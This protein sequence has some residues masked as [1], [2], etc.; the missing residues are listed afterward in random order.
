MSGFDAMKRFLTLVL[1]LFF[2]GEVVAAPNLISP[3]LQKYCSDCHGRAQQ[4]SGVRFDTFKEGVDQELLSRT[5]QVLIDREMPPAAEAQPTEAERNLLLKSILSSAR[6]DTKPRRRLN[7]REFSAA[8]QNLTA[9]TIDFASGLPADG[10]VD[11]FDTGARSLQDASESIDRQLEVTRRAV[12]TLRFVKPPSNRSIQ[13]DF[14]KHKFNDFRK[15]LQQ[16]FDS[17]RITTKSKR[18][19]C[20]SGIGLYLQTQWSGDRGNSFISVPAPKDKNAAM[21]VTIRVVAKRPIRGLPMPTLWV[22]IGGDYIDYVPIGD[23]PQTLSY[24]IRMEDYLVEDGVIKVMLR[25]MVEVPY[26]VDGFENDDKSKPEDK[27]PDGI[28]IYRPRFDRKKL[29]L[30]NEQPVP[31]IVV[32]SLEIDYDYQVAWPPKAWGTNFVA[33]DDD[34]TANR[35]LQIWM[36][37]AYRRPTREFERKRYFDLYRKLRDDGLSFDESLRAAFQATLMSGEFRFFSSP[38]DEDSVVAQ[39]AFASR[40]SFMLV[41]S[42]PDDELRELACEERLL[43]P[44]MLDS[45]VDRLL[46][47]QRCDL[48]FRPFVTQWL[49]MNQPI[50]LSMTHFKKQDFRFGRHLKNSM[51]NET[52]EY[53]KRVFVDNRPAYELIDSDWT[54]MNDILAVH[55]GYPSMDGARLRKVAIVPTKD[56]PRGGGIIGHAG[57]QSMLCWMGDNWVIY[58]GAWALNHILDDPPPPPPLEVPELLPSDKKNHG[59]TFR[60]LL[61]QHQQ[62]ENCSVC[63]R[64][65]DPLGFAFQ[66]FDLSGRWRNQE[67]ERYH[68][69]ELDGK[70]EWRGEGATRPVDTIGRLP[71]GERFE[72]YD[73][74][75]RLV[76]KEYMEQV[77]AGLL[78]KLTLYGTG[79]KPD[80]A[81]IMTIRDIIKEHSKND[82]RMRDVLKS[83]IRSSIFLR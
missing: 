82:F 56:D 60:E 12:E 3:I 37:H 42:L 15:F 26:A 1:L 20:E 18:L 66:N 24:A 31:S 36:D 53:V 27:I 25:C 43:D 8:L 2:S 76:V 50:T 61:A 29:R 19:T 64:K 45:Q 34:V 49:N 22:K 41:G 54:M 79:R 9:T 33:A 51:K 28:G 38:T 7:R 68:R 62:D 23:Q 30:P 70:I 78:K 83:L 10:L 46:E 17:D 14:R 16:Q 63:H 80:A 65:I 21:K 6:N 72:S 59:R 44:K 74:F 5:F 13:I 35:L 71:R 11:G 40:L 75:K 48:F 58:R 77:V 67:S 55:Y 81:D 52:I 57:I 4:Q 69:Y 73:E 47:D 32:E 39:L